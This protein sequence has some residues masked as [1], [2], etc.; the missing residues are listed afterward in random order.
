MEI[1]VSNILQ[2]TQSVT[3][4]EFSERIELP[5]KDEKLLEPVTGDFT[6]TRASSKIL[7][8]E[9]AFH[10]RL[11]LQCDRCGNDF[12]LPVDFTLNE[13]LEVIEEPTTSEEVEEVVSMYGNLDAT[14]LIRQGLLLSLPLRR[15][16]GCEPKNLK[17]DASNLDPRLAAL[18]ALIDPNGNE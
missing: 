9:G 1:P 18:K 15:L 14:D 6:I 7:Q 3:H 16:C 12:E 8:V 2:A 5:S 13:S 10:T 17:D 11:S 4:H